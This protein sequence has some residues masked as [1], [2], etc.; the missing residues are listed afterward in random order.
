MVRT[1]PAHRIV[2]GSVASTTVLAVMIA[3]VALLTSGWAQ[4]MSRSVVDTAKGSVLRGSPAVHGHGLVRFP[5]GFD[6]AGSKAAPDDVG[7]LIFLFREQFDSGGSSAEVKVADV[8][9]DGKPDLLVL[10][11][12][13]HNDCLNQGSVGVLLGNGNGTFQ[14]AV[15]YGT[16]G[17]LAQDLAVA[18]LNGDGK[19]DLVVANCGSES[20]CFGHGSVGV[21]LGKR[22]RHLPAGCGVR[23]GRTSRSGGLR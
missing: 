3:L 11:C 16:G 12:G 9:R 19:L 7:P 15:T 1:L 4:Q 13:D 2:R 10:N 21:L 5:Q 6:K 17:F 8:N 14:S 23:L 22:R 20:D 18:D